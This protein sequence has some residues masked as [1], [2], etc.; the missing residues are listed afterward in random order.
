MNTEVQE[1][2]DQ[3]LEQVKQLAEVRDTDKLVIERLAFNL[4][5]IKKCEDQLLKEGFVMDGLHG[6]KEHPA[7]GIKVKAEGK[8]RENFILLGIDFASQL[9]K[10]TAN[11]GKDDWSDML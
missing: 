6:K 2:Y 11:E 3:I 10:Q 9:K 5:T 1:L 8:M 4:H 7:V